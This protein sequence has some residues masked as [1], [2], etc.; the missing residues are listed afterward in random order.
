VSL[1]GWPHTP[2]T[3]GRVRLSSALALYRAR[4]RRRWL[5]ELLAVLG[6]ALGVALLYA[7]QVAST[8][9]SG[10]VRAINGGLVGKS[11]L[12]LISRGA[13]GMPEA[14]YGQVI[15]LPGVRRAAP[16][17]EVP[18]NLVGPR[19]QRGVMLL[20][21]DPRIVALRGNLLRGFSARDAADQETVVIPAPAARAIGVNVGDDVRVQLGGRSI[22]VPAVVAGREQIGSL[23]S[24]SIALAP[25]AYLQR[26]A[27]S[28]GQVTRILVEARPGR[29]AEVR[30]GLERIAAG[31]VEVRPADDEAKLFDAA[32]RPTSQASIVF[33]VLS[34]LIGWLFAVC[35]LLV[36]A[37]ERRKL[38]A[39]QREQG[40][41]PSATLATLVVDAAAI[42]LAGSA[43]GLMAGE[44]ISRHGFSSDVSFLSGA[45]PIGDQRVVT[46]QSIAIAVIGGFAASAVG[47]L[48]PVREVVIASLPRR[49]RPKTTGGPVGSRRG[50]HAPLPVLGLACLIGAATI[51]FAAPSAAV[52]GLVLL[53]LALMMVLPTLL[54]GMI[55]VLEWCNRRGRSIVAVELALQQLHETRWRSRALAIAATGAV[56]VFGATA[57]QGARSNLQGGLGDLAH[58]L[59]DVAGVWAAPAG[60]GSAIG[61]ASF[62]PSATTTASLAQLPGVASVGLYRAG[63]LDVAGRRAWVLGEPD[64]VLRPIPPHQVL[65]G[66]ELR[67]ARQIRAGGWAAVSRALA[68]DLGLRVGQRFLLR[69][70][71]P[72]A[73]RVAAITTNLGWSGGAIVLNGADFERAWGSSAIAAYHVRLA[74]GASATDVRREVA[75]AL[76]PRSALRVETAA[77][78]ADRQRAVARSGLSRLR[79]IAGLTLLAAVLAMSAAM[80]GLLWQHRP[81]VAERKQHGLGSGL[82]WRS[83]VIET[84]VLF[85]TGTLA[86]G[87][88]G[89]LGQELCTRGV[90][91]VTG[92]PVI[93]DLRLDVA[94]AVT[95]LVIVTSSLVVIVPGY[96]VA[97]VRPSWR[98]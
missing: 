81:S 78:R 30:R 33:S 42:G 46:W 2:V 11:Q 31:R 89:L 58:G 6:I 28:R 88:F 4:L 80:I 3:P 14:T 97:R 98:A 74:R 13:T 47:V 36:T 73:L 44:L 24:T 7:T 53:V 10:P 64:D 49:L 79:Q 50:L 69:A 82:M 92:F 45:F 90:Q 12:Q 57:L 38:A 83:L 21:A 8:S 39:Q 70:P 76:G 34:A 63:L 1:T 52:A 71:T 41:S 23:A 25:L 66:N 75:A 9:L 77:Q 68:D 56:A 16:V 18:G 65:E 32:A 26:L 96:L 84:V 95:G 72:V 40:F 17:L 22:T 37:A 86:G 51:T 59:T 60:A 35:A 54:A 43:I 91:V 55:A 19:G 20:G 15:K 67:A 5:Q 94:A 27:R 62:A 48:A 85:G 29:V 61:T 93:D 87:A